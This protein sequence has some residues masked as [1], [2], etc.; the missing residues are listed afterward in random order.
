MRRSLQYHLGSDKHHMVYE[1]ELVGLT[2][3]AAILQQLD[4]LE[5]ASIAI[6]NQAA[7]KV[8]TSFRSTPGQQITDFFINQMTELTK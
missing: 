6:K 8:I 1:A 2:L 3:A 4:F 5:D 7:V